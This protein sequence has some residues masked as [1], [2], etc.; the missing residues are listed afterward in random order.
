MLRCSSRLRLPTR[1][2]IGSAGRGYAT[3]KCSWRL[4]CCSLQEFAHVVLLVMT[5][6]VNAGGAGWKCMRLLWGWVGVAKRGTAAAPAHAPPST[7]CIDHKRQTDLQVSILEESINTDSLVTCR[8]PGASLS[9][10]YQDEVLQ[11]APT[12]SPPFARGGMCNSHLQLGSPCLN[13]TLLVQLS[14]P[15]QYPFAISNCQATRHTRL[16]DPAPSS[17]R[18]GVQS[19]QCL[20]RHSLLQCG[21]PYGPIW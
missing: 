3:L 8:A 4:S 2:W 21:S 17:R 6:L 5:R 9:T 11:S 18:H 12:C 14:S 19:A 16:S 1:P 15:F 7:R 10:L 13:L 20:P